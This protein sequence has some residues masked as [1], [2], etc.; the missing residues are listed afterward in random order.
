VR[1]VVRTQ[2]TMSEQD[3][4]IDVTRYSS[5]RKQKVLEMRTRN[6]ATEVQSSTETY[7]ND[8]HEWMV[9][10]TRSRQEKV[11]ARYLSGRQFEYYLPLIDRVSWI[12]GRK[13]ISRVPLFPGYVFL[14][15]AAQH[16]YAAVD[17]RRV[18]HVLQVKDQDLFR[19]E[20][21][22]VQLAMERKVDLELY[23][24]AVVGRHCRVTKGPLAGL[25]G[26][27]ARRD[28]KDRLVLHVDVL[29]R[30]AALEIDLDTVE[31]ID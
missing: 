20:L 6:D 26:I 13:S 30:G 24:F 16:W 15:G 7:D 12:R 3:Q 14:C 1:W 19:R 5:E 23:P 2:R 18:S 27:I 22:H 21:H 17:T 9:L 10:C 29:G 25:E 28:R 31:P 4:A 11:V 8:G